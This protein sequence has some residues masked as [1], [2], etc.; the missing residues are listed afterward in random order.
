MLLLL[1]PLPNQATVEDEEEAQYANGRVPVGTGKA[2]HKPR[3][4]TSAGGPC[5]RPCP[6]GSH[7]CTCIALPC[8]N[9]AAAIIPNWAAEHFRLPWLR[10]HALSVARG[11]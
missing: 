2:L 5:P 8:F 10:C 4:R 7:H 3:K 9:K 1:W 6:M 11:A